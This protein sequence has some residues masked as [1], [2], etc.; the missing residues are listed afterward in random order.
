MS[1]GVWCVTD[2]R[3]G[4]EATVRK[5]IAGPEGRCRREACCTRASVHTVP[6][7]HLVRSEEHSGKVWLSIKDIFTDLPTSSFFC[8]VSIRLNIEKFF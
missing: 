4:D 7:A 5:A 8:K 3:L 6:S 2:L 1:V